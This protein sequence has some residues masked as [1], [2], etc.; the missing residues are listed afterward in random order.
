MLFFS[1]CV[2][3]PSRVS[4]LGLFFFPSFGK[5][6]HFFLHVNT[7]F[8][9]SVLLDSVGSCLCAHTHFSPHSWTE[10]G[11]CTHMHALYVHM[12][13]HMCTYMT[14]LSDCELLLMETPPQQSQVLLL[15]SSKQLVPRR[16]HS[17]RKE[18]GR[19]ARLASCLWLRMHPEK[20]AGFWGPGK[21]PTE[22]AASEA[23]EGMRLGSGINS[24]GIQMLRWLGL[25]ILIGS[26]MHLDGSVS[27]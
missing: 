8:F 12:C 13:T 9:S 26:E 1:P 25:E 7:W 3:L 24:K 15:P 20:E 17:G 11:M 22:A 10:L 16:S 23:E 27:E 2:L 6:L 19:R 4:F 14:P 5:C 18:I 21:G